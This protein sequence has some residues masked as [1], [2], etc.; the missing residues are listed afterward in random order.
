[1]V[2]ETMP[3]AFGADLGDLE[4]LEALGDLDGLDGDATAVQGLLMR[5]QNLLGGG[6]LEADPGTSSD[7]SDLGADEREA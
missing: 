5:I 6:E 2:F 4:A 1:M 3:G 7:E